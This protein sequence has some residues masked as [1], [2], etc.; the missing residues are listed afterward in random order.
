MYLERTKGISSTELRSKGNNVKIG[1]IGESP[2]LKKFI[3]ESMYISGVSVTD[4][5]AVNE[6][7][8]F[9]SEYDFI[10]VHDDLKSML[11]LV[12]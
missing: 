11:S 10:K 1:I 8:E 3:G 12:E 5:F 9:I 6:V 7:P 2:T 4:I